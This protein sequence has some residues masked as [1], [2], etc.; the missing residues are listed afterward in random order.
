VFRKKR[1]QETEKVMFGYIPIN[2][3]ILIPIPFSVETTLPPHTKEMCQRT[4]LGPIN[5]ISV[6]IF[7][8]S[9]EFVVTPTLTVVLYRRFVFRN[10]I[11]MCLDLK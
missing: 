6:P 11:Q 1:S 8:F 7:F 2:N 4:S 9:N 5:G 10:K 3:S